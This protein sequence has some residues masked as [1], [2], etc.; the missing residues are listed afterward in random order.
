MRPSTKPGSLGVAARGLLAFFILLL[1]AAV[2]L[3][4]AHA[5]SVASPGAAVGAS[6]ARAKVAR[7]LDAAEESLKQATAILARPDLSD[8]DF[9]RLR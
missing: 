5:Q 8:G 1:L 7:A 6:E 2:T 9:A 4:P 3:G